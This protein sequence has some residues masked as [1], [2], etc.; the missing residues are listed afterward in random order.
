MLVNIDIKLSILAARWAPSNK[1]F[2]LGA[3]CSTLALGYYNSE[4]KCWLISTRSNFIKSPI[5]TLSF[6]PS[7]NLL[8][9]GSSDFSLKVVTASFKKS[10]DPNV[11]ASKVEEYTYD[12]P[13]K[14]IDSLFEVI[15]TIDNLGGW[16]NHVSFENKGNKLLVIPHH[17]HIKVF[18]IN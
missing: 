9:V 5:T 3:S 10:K 14:N 6:H 8:A 12:G 18:E 15:F 13:F 17:N 11:I 16:I 1:K 2:S 7:S 4:E